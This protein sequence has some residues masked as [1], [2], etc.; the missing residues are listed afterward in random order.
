L[1]QPRFGSRYALCSPKGVKNDQIRTLIA[2]P[3]AVVETLG[4]ALRELPVEVYP[5]ITTADA[6]AHLEKDLDLILVCYVFDDVRPYRFINR[7]RNESSHGRTP[8]ILVRALPVP[9]GES[10]EWEIRQAYKSIGVDEFINYSQ[11]LHQNGAPHANRALRECVS[12]LLSVS[13]HR[14]RSA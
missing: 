8:L 3:P 6:A 11:L 2:A 1:A 10:Q 12:K 4:N 5:G 13:N 14:I 7:I 9:L